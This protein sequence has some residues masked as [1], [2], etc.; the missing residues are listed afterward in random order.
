MPKR[1]E[2]HC[3]H[4]DAEVRI[5]QGAEYVCDTPGCNWLGRYPVAREKLELN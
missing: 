3:P 5:S 4:C 2:F 1:Y